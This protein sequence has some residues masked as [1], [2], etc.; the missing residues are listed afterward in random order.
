MRIAIYERNLLWSSRFAQAARALGHESVVL[1][2]HEPVAS[3]VALVNLSDDAEALRTLI[4]ALRGQGVYVIGHAGHKE[5]PLLAL[6]NE[7]GCDYVATNGEI[8]HKFASLL[9]S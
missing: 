5:K 6:G 7:F 8:T 4:G 3:E 1:T 2:N 9:P